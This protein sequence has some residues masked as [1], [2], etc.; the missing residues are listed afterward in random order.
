MEKDSFERQLEKIVFQAD[1]NTSNV[2]TSDRERVW[3]NVKLKNK[4]QKWWWI[5]SAA[6]VIVCVVLAF[7]QIKEPSKTI[8]VLKDKPLDKRKI[9]VKINLHEKA[10]AISIKTPQ[11]KREKVKQPQ[12]T[13]NITDEPAFRLIDN[14]PINTVD[15]TQMANIKTMVETR[16][17]N[18]LQKVAEPEFTVQF[19]RGTTSFKNVDEGQVYTTLKKFKLKRDT[20]YFATVEEKQPKRMK[21]SFKKEN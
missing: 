1:Q 7:Y 19:K 13:A 2:T 20:T 3:N 10:Q 18:H 21:L 17:E 15:A 9:P 12:P 14:K 8:A 6:A 11:A 16:V 4:P 5:S